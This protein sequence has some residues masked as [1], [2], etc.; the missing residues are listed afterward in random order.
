MSGFPHKK[1]KPNDIQ[2]TPGKKMLFTIVGNPQV[3][4]LPTSVISWGRNATQLLAWVKRTDWNDLSQAVPPKTDK[5]QQFQENQK[6]YGLPD[7]WVRGANQTLSTCVPKVK[8]EEPQQKLL[9]IVV[10][11]VVFSFP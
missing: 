2:G 6:P 10:V 3:G 8:L 7:S 11:I 1:H 4:L 9:G 5:T